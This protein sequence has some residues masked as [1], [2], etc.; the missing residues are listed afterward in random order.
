MAPHSAKFFKQHAEAA[1]ANLDAA[2]L[3]IRPIIFSLDKE[4]AFAWP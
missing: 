1:T 3:S 2:L 4:L